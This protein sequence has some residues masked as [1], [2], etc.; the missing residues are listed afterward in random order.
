ME[1]YI[2]DF[3]KKEN[4][5]DQMADALAVLSDNH[6]YLKQRTVNLPGKVF[7]MQ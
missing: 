4:G 7:R 6:R 1:D 2:N 3:V 5:G